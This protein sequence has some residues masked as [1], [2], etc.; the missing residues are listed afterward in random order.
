[1]ISDRHYRHLDRRTAGQQ[2]GAHTMEEKQMRQVIKKFDEKKRSFSNKPS[3]V[4]LD[5]PDP[6][7]ILNIPGRVTQGDL[8]INQ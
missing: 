7:H 3:D 6:L 8:R 2:I 1:M 4:H 5:L